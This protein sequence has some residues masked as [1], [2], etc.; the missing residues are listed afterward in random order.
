MW[1][2]LTAKGREGT[3]EEDRNIPYFDKSVGHRVILVI[4]H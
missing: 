3:F 4:P 1:E 2:E